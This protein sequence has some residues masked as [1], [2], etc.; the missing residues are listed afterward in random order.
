MSQMTINTIV[1]PFFTIVLLFILILAIRRKKKKWLIILLSILLIW[2]TSVSAYM[3]TNFIENYKYPYSEIKIKNQKYYRNGK[4][5]TGVST[6][7][8]NKDSVMLKIKNGDLDYKKIFLSLN[9]KI[10][11]SE[12]YLPS[13]FD[14]KR[15]SRSAFTINEKT[16]LSEEYL[17]EGKL[18]NM[19]VKDSNRTLDDFILIY[20][21]PN[22]IEKENNR[23]FYSFLIEEE[24][25]EC[26]DKRSFVGKIS[27]EN[28]LYSESGCVVDQKLITES[29]ENILSK[30]KGKYFVCKS[31]GSVI[32]SLEIRYDNTFILS[33][34]TLGGSASEGTWEIYDGDDVGQANIILYPPPAQVAAGNIAK[35]IYLVVNEN[36]LSIRVR[37]SDTVYELKK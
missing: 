37:G 31:Y 5:F 28:P 8:N 1:F 24:S 19:L 12:S 35:E 13:E 6:F 34:K 36:D 21:K 10:E 26:S 2:T 3:I 9:K 32:G 25:S 11:I 29:K 17:M 18:W 22:K 23:T 15:I 30:I 27:F 14:N 4:L 33:T 16:L 20:G 7:M